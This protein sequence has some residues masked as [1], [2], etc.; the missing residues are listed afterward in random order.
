MEFQT[1]CSKRELFNV[2]NAVSSDASVP[3]SCVL[4]RSI[5]LLFTAHRSFRRRMF[6]N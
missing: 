4:L 5:D 6:G 2:H 1:Q 3:G